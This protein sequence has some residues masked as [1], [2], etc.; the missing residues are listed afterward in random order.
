MLMYC[1]GGV[2]CEKAS[3]L[4][5]ERCDSA[6]P[7]SSDDTEIMQLSGGIERYLQ[8]YN[9]SGT[10]GDSSQGNSSDSSV[11]QPVDEPASDA[12]QGHVGAGSMG[13]RGSPLE[14]A[15]NG[16]QGFFRGKNFV[17]DDR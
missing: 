15:R 10:Q 2:R 17:F 11:A 12:R 13:G 14:Q 5:R 1:T 6:A 7:S 9:S 3:A 8:L 4:L 16:D